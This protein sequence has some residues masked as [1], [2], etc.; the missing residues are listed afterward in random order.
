MFGDGIRCA[1]GSV[2]RPGHQD[3]RGRLVGA[4]ALIH[5]KGNDI[6]GNTR[7]YQCWYRNA[8]AFC[9]RRST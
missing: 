4:D 2:T 3:E 6:A 8:A 7:Q 9:L 1:G 5:V